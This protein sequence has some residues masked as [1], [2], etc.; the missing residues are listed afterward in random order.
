V[1]SI[2]NENKIAL[3]STLLLFIVMLYIAAFISFQS[4]RE[5]YKHVSD[6]AS[7]YDDD[8]GPDFNMYCETLIRC[9]TSTINYGIRAGGGIGDVLEQPLYSDAI[10]TSRYVYD[11][12]FFMVINIILMNIFFGIIIDSFAD[13]R[14]QESLI[15]AEVQD[16]CFICGISKSTFEIENVPWKQHIF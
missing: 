7:D 15:E 2:F 10:Y 16:L 11:F 6:E 3:G 12:T 1:L 9:L 14:A 8:H 4:F 5:T 13:K